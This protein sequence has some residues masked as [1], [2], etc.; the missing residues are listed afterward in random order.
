MGEVLVVIKWKIL[1]KWVLCFC[2][3][4]LENGYEGVVFIGF[5]GREIEIMC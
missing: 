2:F 3:F 4:Y 1:G 5:L